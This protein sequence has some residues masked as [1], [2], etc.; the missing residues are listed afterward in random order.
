V[1][2]P[3][4]PLPSQSLARMTA[5]RD[6]VTAQA[7][8]IEGSPVYPIGSRVNDRGRL[9]VGGCD[10]VEL[11]REFG[12][13]AYV[14]APADIR[15][16]ANAYL[17]AL[18]S[19]ADRFEL[20][21][22]SKA[23]PI[24]AIGRLLA[25]EGLSIDVASGGELHTA[26]RS[27]F[28]PQR[29]HMHGN[30]KSEDE[31]R[32]AVEAGVGYVICDSLDEIER[33]DAICGGAGRTQR[34]LIRVTPGVKAETHSY[35]QTGQLDSK[36]GLGLADGLAQRGVDAALASSN[37]ELVGV[38]AHIGSQIFELEPYVKAIEALAELADPGWCELLNLGGG[39]GIAYTRDDQPP[40][41]EE[42]VELKVGAVE[43]VFDPVPKIVI[44]P[45]RSLVGNAGITVYTVGTVKEIPGVR[46]YVAVEGGMSDN[47]RPMLYG[48][49]YEAIVADRAAEP[50]DTTATV[51]G[52]HCE[53]ADMI[54]RDARLASP[55]LGDVLVTP[56]TGAYGY[57]MAN[58]YNA[59]PRPPVIFCED[60]DARIVVRRETYEDLTN[61]D[62][63][64]ASS[65]S[66]SE[67][68]LL[69]APG[70]TAPEAPGAA[71]SAE[72][73]GS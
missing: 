36:F 68:M 60:G 10:V 1:P 9:E 21:Y 29:I 41:I 25:G 38:H 39:L 23:A 49:R 65:P 59:V 30:N 43:R 62:V 24:T 72:D 18:R 8:P 55:R 32:L 35:V 26:L 6:A 64:P 66:E 33:L 15:A 16:R 22:A 54:V 48:A 73:R 12:T 28:D 69:A 4:G 58:N 14:Y 5:T 46:T 45:G 2:P 61:R 7:S 40:T 17:G 37:L 42:Y 3:R 56:A 34:V 47:L 20:V 52:M 44:E 11:A 71:G 70:G 51:A 13:P 67:D 31:L 27:G 53:S 63:P 19:R 57:A 50:P